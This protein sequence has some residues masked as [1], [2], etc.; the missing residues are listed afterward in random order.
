MLSIEVYERQLGHVD[1]LRNEWTRGK[2][3]RHFRS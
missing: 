2:N 1:Q 3:S